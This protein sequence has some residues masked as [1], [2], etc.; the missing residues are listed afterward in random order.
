MARSSA[1]R[2]LRAVVVGGGVVGLCTAWFLQEHGAEVTVIEREVIGAGASHGNAGWVTPGMAAPL[3]E[4][5]VLRGGGAM[6]LS[7]N[8]PVS[9]RPAIDPDLVRFLFGFARNATTTRWQHGMAALAPLNRAAFDAFDV[10]GAA[11]VTAGAGTVSDIVAAWAS[12]RQRQA[13]AEEL[14]HMAS[15]GVSIDAEEVG[16]DE[17]RALQPALSSRIGAGLVLRAQRFVEPRALSDALALSVA[18]RGGR[19]RTGRTVTGISATP[20]EVVVR[21]KD[22]DVVADHVVIATG[23]ELTRL[24]RP[25]GVRRVVQAGRGYSFSVSPA[26]LP[27]APIYLPAARLACTPLRGRLRIAGL[28]EFSRPHASFLPRRIRTMTAAASALLTGVDFEDRHEEWVGSR[29]VTADGIPFIG[30]TRDPRVH[31]AGGHGMWGV[32]LGAV[33]GRMLAR[34]VMS[35]EASP[36]LAA[37]DPLR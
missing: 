13:F 36:E 1:R 8:A 23:A 34:Q 21:T 2:P 10:L 26:D 6:L 12:P 24:A 32:T 19:I 33:T 25:F 17:A 22:D 3:P 18:E 7:P 16:G 15:F 29:P 27:T 35:G 11:G 28:M 14:R 31:V 20:R 4:P 30:R 5:S 37:F 9:I